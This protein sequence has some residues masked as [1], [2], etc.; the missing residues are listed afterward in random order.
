MRE[1]A[2]TQR[3]SWFLLT[4]LVASALQSQPTVGRGP[5]MPQSAST[6]KLEAPQPVPNEEAFAALK[7]LEDNGTL[8]LALLGERMSK[9]MAAKSSGPMAKENC[10]GW[11]L[12]EKA[13]VVGES[14]AG[15][16]LN[17]KFG[18]GDKEFQVLGFIH[19][20]ADISIGDKTV[21]AGTYSIYANRDELVLNSK[22]MWASF[23]E[24][25][26]SLKQ[27]LD[28][29]FFAT[30]DSKARRYSLAVDQDSLWLV[31]GDN[32]LSVR[33]SKM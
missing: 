23:S 29:S 15:V 30:S 33:L 24:L 17:F 3:V 26:F 25:H 13:R 11:R 14:P 4:L 32:R 8:V 20:E 16:N 5:S 22:E 12:S 6:L 27:P 19:S 10:F 9:L 2:K 21:K 7:V 28:S 31:V 18:S 1:K